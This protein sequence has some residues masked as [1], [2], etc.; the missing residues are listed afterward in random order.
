MST[1]LLAYL[2]DANLGR[3]C[4]A[5]ATNGSFQGSLAF[6]SVI[7][8]IPLQNTLGNGGLYTVR[9]GILIVM[10]YIGYI[11]TA[12]KGESWH[13]EGEERELKC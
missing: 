1:S 6:V 12:R 9:S 5:V 4:T 10:E 3:S 11:G 13:K 7:T 8:P 2:V